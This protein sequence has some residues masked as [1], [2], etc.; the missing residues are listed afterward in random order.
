MVEWKDGLHV[1][2]GFS[3][4]LLSVAT[5]FGVFIFVFHD[6]QRKQRRVELVRGGG[7]CRFPPSGASSTSTEVQWPQI[8]ATAAA[9]VEVERAG[10]WF[11][12]ATEFH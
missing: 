3:R 1:T 4:S 10:W 2:E 11:K 6:K 12:M 9:V 8:E 5:S 7:Q